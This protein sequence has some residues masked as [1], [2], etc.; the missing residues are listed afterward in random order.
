[1][2][3]E[4]WKHGFARVHGVRL[5]YVEQGEGPLVLLL[6]GFPE[7]WYSWRKQIPV[8]GQH[9]HVVAPDMRGYN[10]SD[11]PEGVKSYEMPHLVGD[12]LGLVRFFG[13]E[14]AVV[15]GHDWGGVVAWA[16]ALMYPGATE[17]LVVCNAPHV[18]AFQ[19]LSPAERLRQLQMSWYI[20]FFQL[21]EVPERFIRQGDFAFVDFAFQTVKPG[22]FTAEDL[23][24]YK[25][26]L[27]KPGALAAAIN[28]YRANIRPELLVGLENPPVEA[29]KV[30]RPTL[31]LW[32]EEDLALSKA[33]A[34]RTGEFV[35]APYTYRP[36]SGCGHWVQNE[37]PELVN[38]YMLE[39]LADLRRS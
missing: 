25:K 35:S 37:E 9:F 32:G 30:T 27:A 38:R 6:H 23:A 5:H 29:L 20:F 36:I 11:K 16:F 39:F 2:A 28:Y 21:P 31:L 7:F 8:L 33:L 1:M 19:R 12:V 24:E 17:R 15:V 10:D 4:S 34:E 18:G 14:R 3:A 22:G 13:E 26:A